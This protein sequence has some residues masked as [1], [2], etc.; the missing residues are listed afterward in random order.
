M[1]GGN[2]EDKKILGS[3][4]GYLSFL[5]SDRLRGN[6]GPGSSSRVDMKLLVGAVEGSQFTGARYP[7]KVSALAQLAESPRNT[8]NS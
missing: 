7:F 6:P 8:R 1:T 5:F 2:H 3:R 4:G